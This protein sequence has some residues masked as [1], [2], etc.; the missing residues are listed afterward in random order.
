MF[1]VIRAF[2]NFHKFIKSD[3]EY[4]DYTYLWDIVCLSSQTKPTLFAGGVNLVI[5]DITNDDLT[6]RID[7]LCPSSQYSKHFHDKDKKNTIMLIKH[8]NINEESNVYYDVFEPIIMY[9]IK[10]PPDGSIT[11][12]YNPLFDQKNTVP[13]EI[14]NTISSIKKHLYDKCNPFDK[15]NIPGEHKFKESITLSR[16]RE[17]LN[18]F[19]EDTLYVVL[20]FDYKCI[21]IKIKTKNGLEGF[22]PC[23][24]SA[25]NFEEYKNVEFVFIDNP[26]V[27][28]SYDNTITFLKEVKGFN[29]EIPCSP[30]YLLEELGMIVGIFT[31][32]KQCIQ[33]NPPIKNDIVR[34]YPVEFTLMNHIPIDKSIYNS[35][36]D[37]IKNS[38]AHKLKCEQ[39][40]LNA[41]RLL[42]RHKLSLLPSQLLHSKIMLCINDDEISYE[43]K[44]KKISSIL[45]KLTK[46]NVRFIT[47][48]AEQLSKISNV[49]LCNSKNTSSYCDKDI[50]LIPKVNLITNDYNS[51]TYF[52]KVADELIR[53][54][55]TR[56]FILDPKQLLFF[57]TESSSLNNDEI[58]VYDSELNSVFFNTFKAAHQSDYI[59]NKTADD[60]T[61]NDS[62]YSFVDTI[63]CFTVKLLGKTTKQI[64][65]EQFPA[66]TFVRTYDNL[67]YCTIQL[68]ADIYQA[69]TNKPITQNKVKDDLIAL[70]N[71]QI[72]TNKLQFFKAMKRQKKNLSKT[73]DTIDVETFVK[74][75][76]F[77]VC[78]L[79]IWMFVEK[80][81]IPTILLSNH[82][83]GF[84]ENIRS[85]MIILHSLESGSDI[86]SS[87][88]FIITP[89]MQPNKPSKY[90][91]LTRKQELDT[92]LFDINTLT[93]SR[94]DTDS[95]LTSVLYYKEH[96]KEFNPKRKM[97]RTRNKRLTLTDYIS[98]EVET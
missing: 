36:F 20:S 35:N 32:T 80:Y 82:Q 93:T 70:Y 77:Y 6:N 9:E 68:L 81:Q 78:N 17:M 24:P 56:D 73:A 41:F 48:T 19:I 47:Y 39:T 52:A 85:K 50:L 43:V 44:I 5:L 29:K 51:R 59:L 96:Y 79:D 27:W 33:L 94:T 67:S 2:E 58:L 84:D 4:I 75:D 30:V 28:S 14:R 25:I 10:K 40:F 21:G 49:S 63:D 86:D 64:K 72:E 54:K 65:D 26:V 90:Q 60:L 46:D 55:T 53:Y 62:E 31:E 15:P 45:I 38:Y 92:A 8:T 42:C 88:I 74:N 87:Y 98:G 7:I 61:N 66:K 22:L 12:V 11:K 89:G 34:E 37:N 95:I 1:S 97:T 57:P 23:F 16:L 13:I 3:D 91:M 83:S 76:D 71:E 69:Y 18:K